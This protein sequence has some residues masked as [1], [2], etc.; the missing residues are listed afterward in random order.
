[1]RRAWRFV[2]LSL[3]FFLL[4]ALVLGYGVYRD[5]TFVY[6]L[7]PASEVRNMEKMYSNRKLIEQ[8]RGTQG[9]AA[10]FGYY[11]EHNIG[12][13]FQCFAGGLFFGLGSLFFLSYNGMILGGV[14]TKKYIGVRCLWRK[15]FK[16]KN[17]SRN[18]THKHFN[19]H[20]DTYTP[21]L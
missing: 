20:T 6:S 9:D 16:Y 4:P 14:A 10:M 18:E 15:D 12:I 8:G 3:A 11:I 5:D 17:L 21:F 7:M 1:M 19:Q 2:A 13:G